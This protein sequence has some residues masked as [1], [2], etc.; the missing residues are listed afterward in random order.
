M[1]I[2]TVL[3]LNLP[4]FLNF[5]YKHISLY[6]LSHCFT[7]KLNTIKIMTFL[8]IK[9]F[10]VF[11]IFLLFKLKIINAER[12]SIFCSTF[13]F[14]LTACLVTPHRDERERVVCKKRAAILFSDGRS[15]KTN[16]DIYRARNKMRLWCSFLYLFPFP[17]CHF[18]TAVAAISR[19]PRDNVFIF[20]CLSPISFSY[21][22][23]RSSL[24]TYLDRFAIF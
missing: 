12:F 21:Q 8:Y 23:I 5:N 15:R 24:S 11:V 22:S 3:E 20:F 1:L 16:R 10:A 14:T 6:L 13:D 17:Q 2:L 9:N 18:F 4:K 19:L 7:Q